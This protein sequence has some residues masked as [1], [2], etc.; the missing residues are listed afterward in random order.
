MLCLTLTQAAEK[1]PPPL[2]VLHRPLLDVWELKKQCWNLGNTLYCLSQSQVGLNRGE[3][4]LVVDVW[5][6]VDCLW[7]R[8]VSAAAEVKYYCVVSWLHIWHSA[9][10]D[11]YGSAAFQLHLV[12]VLLHVLGSGT[13]TSSPLA[14]S[15]SNGLPACS[16]FLKQEN[17]SNHQLQCTVV[18]LEYNQPPDK[19]LKQLI[20]KTMSSESARW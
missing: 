6:Y 12:V 18:V 14:G 9:W 2:H 1:V 20:L 7:G 8:W 17:D 3:G 5:W 15:A 13:W 10:E 19:R 16:K 4:H 11:I